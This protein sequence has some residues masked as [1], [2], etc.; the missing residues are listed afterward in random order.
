MLIRQVPLER[1]PVRP[2][3]LDGDNL[4]I[5]LDQRAATA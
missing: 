5:G 2:D 1:D 3:C 4:A